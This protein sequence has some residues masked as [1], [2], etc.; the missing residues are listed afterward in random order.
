MPFRC[1]APTPSLWLPSEFFGRNSTRALI[2]LRHSSGVEI[3]LSICLGIGLSAACGFRVFV[4]LLCLSIGAKL[5]AFP[6]TEG[7]AWV[8]TTPAITA[9]AVATAA[10]IAAYYIPWVDNALD[11]IAVPAASLAG[12]LAMGSVLPDVDPFWR[13]TLAVIAGG[14]IATSTQVATTKARLTST[15][16]TGGLAN[17]VLAT[18][19][20]ASSTALSVLAIVWPIVAFILGL[21]VLAASITIIYFVGKGVL[22]LFRRKTPVPVTMAS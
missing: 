11:S 8:G 12:T 17:P 16:A 22:K 18:I 19:E 3:F 14:G 20:S 7:F 10:E 5:G 4:P 15:V 1:E 21:T 6:L 9:L 13:W 2:D